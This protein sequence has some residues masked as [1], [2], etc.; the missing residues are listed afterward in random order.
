[1]RFIIKNNKLIMQKFFTED[2][3]K[4]S[5]IPAIPQPPPDSN[6]PYNHDLQKLLTGKQFLLDD[7]PFQHDNL[8]DHYENGYITFRK[9]IDYN[10]KKP[11]CTRCGNKDPQWFAVYP[12]ARCG[13]TCLYCRHCLM[14]GRISECTP[15]FGWNGPVPDTM[16]PLKIMDW[17]GTLSKGQQA[18]SDKV[19][20]AILNKQELLV[21]A[22]CVAGNEYIIFCVKNSTRFLRFRRG[23]RFALLTFEQWLV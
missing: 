21:W 18:A 13:E 19:V 6:Y 9:G 11:I 4:I 7:I 8:Q 20:E 12:C 5:Q 14:M 16:L 23:S 17:Q 2:S 1:M 10:G 22:V 15:L 3:L